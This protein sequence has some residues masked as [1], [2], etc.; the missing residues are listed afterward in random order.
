[1]RL[2][3][4]ITPQAAGMQLRMPRTF[5]TYPRINCRGWTPE[6]RRVRISFGSVSRSERTM[7]ETSDADQR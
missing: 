2:H 5:N 6:G 1:M 4:I 3:V 7:S